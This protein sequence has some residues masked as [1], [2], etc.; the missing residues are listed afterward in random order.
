ME[1]TDVPDL[2]LIIEFDQMIGKAGIA[3][4]EENPLTAALVQVRKGDGIGIPVFAFLF[5][6][7]AILI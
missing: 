4:E 5:V 3:R 2:N 6:C 1:I 7:F